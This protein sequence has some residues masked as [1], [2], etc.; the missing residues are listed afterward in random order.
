MILINT[1]KSNLKEEIE[2]LANQSDRID[3][4]T[5]FFTESNLIKQW[6]ENEIIVRLLFS[7]RPPTSFC[8]LKEIQSAKNVEINFLGNDFHSK[9]I[10]F[11][12]NDQSFGA[13]IGSSNFTSGG[14]LKNIETNIYTEERKILKDLEKHYDDLTGDSNLLQ[15]TDLAEYKLIYKNWLAKQPKE[16]KISKKF[17]K[18]TTSNRTKRGKK[19]QIIKVAREYHQYWKIVDE[20]KDV[21]KDVA[22]SAYPNIPIYLILDHFWHYVKIIWHNETKRKLSDINQKEEIIELF[23]KYIK[24]NRDSE[25]SILPKDMAR[26]S[27]D[28]FQIYLSKENI[29]RLTEE[30]AK[31]IFGGLHSTNM[32]IQRFKADDLFIT[33]NGMAKIRNSL[34]YLIHSNDD[35]ELKIHNLIKNPKYKLKRFG[36][37]GVQE[38]N[39]WTKPREYPIRNEKSN[40]AIEILGY[41]ID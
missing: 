1:T 26:L 12:K 15:P 5:A 40:D 25:E 38:L 21:L 24:W 6:S 20:I 18:K 22:E 31:Q 17:E 34:S 33:E 11:Y 23:K 4:A 14:L 10:I 36:S 3:L 29:H 7:F 13:I 30:Q 27:K 35:I 19:P 39:G 28:V 32:S 2:R 8:S 16:N 37:S 9:F 41:L